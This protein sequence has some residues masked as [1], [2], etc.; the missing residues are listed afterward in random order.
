[1]DK[2]SAPAAATLAGVQDKGDVSQRA[3]G[4][5][6]AMLGHTDVVNG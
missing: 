6:Q 2:D 3:E 4:K 1:M 5:G